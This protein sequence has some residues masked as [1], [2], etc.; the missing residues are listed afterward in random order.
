[1]FSVQYCFIWIPLDFTVSEDP[2]NHADKKILIYSIRKFRREQ[3]QS[4]H[5][6]MSF[7]IYEEILIIYVFIIFIIFSRP[8]VI[9]DFATAPF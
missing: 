1:M 3:L 7:L 4:H 6:I 5:M 9:Y 2:Y 8:L